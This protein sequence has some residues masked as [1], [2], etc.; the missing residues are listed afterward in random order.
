MSKPIKLKIKP[1]FD[2]LLFGLV[3][4]EPIYRL[5]W[6]INDA[7]GILLTESKSLQVYHTKR[8]IIQEFAKFKFAE[9]EGLVIHLIQNK[10]QQGIFIEE[11]KL[12]D[13]WLKIESSTYNKSEVLQQIK[14]IKNINLVFEI[15]PD[16]LKSKDRLLIS[17]P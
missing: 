12:V 6:L 14:L 9:N 7:I 3:T 5:S 4:S 17:L 8:Q 16:S 15:K 1:E 11:Q 13:F 10:S 2:F